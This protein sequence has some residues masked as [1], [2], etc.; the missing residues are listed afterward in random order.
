MYVSFCTDGVVAPG[1]KGGVE[2]VE[3]APFVRQ[4]NRLCAWCC[5]GREDS[6]ETEWRGEKEAG[7]MKVGDA[8]VE[9]ESIMIASPEIVPVALLLTPSRPRAEVNEL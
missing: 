7:G 4:S 6:V 9:T 1:D 8:A 3:V 2:M 5:E